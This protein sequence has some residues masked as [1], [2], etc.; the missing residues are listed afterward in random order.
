MCRTILSLAFATLSAFALLAVPAAAADKDQSIVL[1]EGKL[2]LQA[3]E[4]WVRKEP[5]SRII[6]HEFA[7]EG[8]KDQEPGRITIMGAGGSI[9]QNINRWIG[10]FV[11]PEGKKA[12]ELTKVEKRKI[13]GID[14][15][16]VDVSGTYKDT[17]GGGPFSGGKT[18]ER[19]NYR[20]LAAI[21][22]GG[23]SIGNYFIKFYGPADLVKANEKAFYQVIESLKRK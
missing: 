7:V 18:V 10:Q 20:M 16:I 4:S 15:R 12:K 3:P 11:L 8:K 21:I 19:K 13:A 5:R 1:G 23:P 22:E 17:V 9:E 6:E 2:L 14:T